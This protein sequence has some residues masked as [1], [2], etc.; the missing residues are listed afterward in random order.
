[1]TL[2]ISLLIAV[3]T[4]GTVIG[5]LVAGVGFM[6]QISSGACLRH[7]IRYALHLLLTCLAATTTTVIVFVSM[8]YFLG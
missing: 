2:E 6:S 4:S 7:S 5:L 8:F 1:M 3:A